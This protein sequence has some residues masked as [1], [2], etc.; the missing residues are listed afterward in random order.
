[1][2]EAEADGPSRSPAA[3]GVAE[4]SLSR[5]V[6]DGAETLCLQLRSYRS[7]DLAARLGADPDWSMALDCV[8]IDPDHDGRVFRARLADAPPG[9]REEILGHYEL[10][11]FEVGSAVAV[12]LVD[13][14]GAE[15]LVVLPTA[16]DANG[17]PTGQVD[18]RPPGR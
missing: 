17:S 16:T 6:R 2:Y 13:V 14:L 5:E 1:V 10:P 18:T 9:R 11:M 12:K 15:T 7:T 8:L 4:V 3:A